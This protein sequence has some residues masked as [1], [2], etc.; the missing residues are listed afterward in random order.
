MT[1]LINSYVIISRSYTEDDKTT[2]GFRPSAIL[3]RDENVFL[4]QNKASYFRSVILFQDVRTRRADINVGR[5][6]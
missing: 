2:R 1:I 6:K 4:S 3:F 5:F